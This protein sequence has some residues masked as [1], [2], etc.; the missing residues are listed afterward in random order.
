[1]RPNKN[2]NIVE[3]KDCELNGLP[4]VISTLMLNLLWG[5]EGWSYRTAP[6][7]LT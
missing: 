5:R 1:M 3:L 6:H 2:M 7:A 4:A